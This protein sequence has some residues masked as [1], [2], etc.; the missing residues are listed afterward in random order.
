MKISDLKK[1]I[2][3]EVHNVLANSAFKVTPKERNAVDKF[4]RAMPEYMNIP[5]KDIERIVDKYL[6]EYERNKRNYKSIQD[7]LDEI[8]SESSYIEMPY[9][10]DY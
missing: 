4:V 8:D 3:E 2:K 10:T 5:L 9:K 6:T 7:Y 1:I